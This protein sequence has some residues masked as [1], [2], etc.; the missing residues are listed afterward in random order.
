MP[1]T[2]DGGTPP[3][4]PL[5]DEVRIEFVAELEGRR[6]TC[7]GGAQSGPGSLVGGRDTF[8]GS[9][10]GRL[11]IYGDPS[12]R[13]LELVDLIERPEG[14][15]EERVWCDEQFVFLHE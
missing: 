4:E 15:S 11:M 8:V 10:S 6:A 7:E 5:N 14:F 13:W 2:G 12:W 9:L 1:A 3:N